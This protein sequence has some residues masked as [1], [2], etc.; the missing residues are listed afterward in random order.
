MCQ[1]YGIKLIFNLYH[2]YIEKLQTIRG[3]ILN[4]LFKNATSKSLQFIYIWS[5]EWK[6]SVFIEKRIP[7]LCVKGIQYSDRNFKVM[8]N[9]NMYFVPTDQNYWSLQSFFIYRNKIDLRNPWKPYWQ[10]RWNFLRKFCGRKHGIP[11]YLC[12]KMHVFLRFR[13][14]FQDVD[15]QI[16][17]YWTKL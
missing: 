12:V 9:R 14:K 8:V 11:H 17:E 4:F 5:F 1:I 15:A 6:R 2:L 16:A 10:F 13:T 7:K 3:K